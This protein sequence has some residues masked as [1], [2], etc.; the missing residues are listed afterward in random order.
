MKARYPDEGEK[1][2]NYMRRKKCGRDEAKFG[3][4]KSFHGLGQ[5][6]YWGLAKMQFQALMT[7]IVVYVKRMVTVLTGRPRWVMV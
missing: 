2:R 5:A 3:E 6:W 4:M 1:G 7:A